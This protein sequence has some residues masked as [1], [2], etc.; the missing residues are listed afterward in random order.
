MCSSGGIA[1]DRDVGEPAEAQGAEWFNKPPRTEHVTPPHQDNFYFCL[2]PAQVLTMWLALDDVDDKNGCLRY[3]PGSH[4]RGIRPHNRTKTLG[5]SQG[6]VDYGDR[7]LEIEAAIHAQ[8][9]DV[10]IHHGDMIHRAEANRSNTRHR[11]SFAMVV[12]GQSCRRDEAAYQR[13][14]DAAT[15][16]HQNMGLNVV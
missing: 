15:L 4:L 7:D 12:R 6:I 13:Y 14:L 2:A 10:L 8:P 5:F 3:V 11:R 1:V 16:H 9:G